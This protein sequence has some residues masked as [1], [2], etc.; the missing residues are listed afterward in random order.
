MQSIYELHKHVGETQR[1]MWTR[2]KK[3]ATVSRPTSHVQRHVQSAYGAADIYLISWSVLHRGLRNFVT[4]KK[5]KP[6]SDAEF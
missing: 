6:L 2:L 3:H 1:I 4:R 5:I